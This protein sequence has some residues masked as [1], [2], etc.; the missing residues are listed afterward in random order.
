MMKSAGGERLAEV[1]R[2]ELPLVE[3]P[4][5]T[6]LRVIP[7]H[8]RPTAATLEAIQKQAYDEGF[9]L[10][11]QAGVRRGMLEI[12]KQVKRL[13]QVLT[14]LSTP[15]A[16]LDEAVIASIADLAILIARH[17]VRRELKIDPGEVVGVVRETMRML[18]IATRNARIHLHPEDVELV[19]SALAITDES[20]EWRLE[21]D[22]RMT[23]GGCIVETDSSRIDASVE[24]RLAAIASKMLGG[25]RGGD[26][27]A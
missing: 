5:V 13:D 8:E 1:V 7:H 25:E 10:G 6:D 23:R 16:E 24:S 18:P 26:R 3:G 21:P 14:Q 11:Q 17:L 2:F 4:I 12:D 9:A 15:F 22:P 20:R 27:A 19:R